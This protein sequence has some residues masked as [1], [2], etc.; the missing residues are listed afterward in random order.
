MKYKWKNLTEKRNEKQRLKKPILRLLQYQKSNGIQRIIVKT[1]DRETLYTCT[2]MKNVF[3]FSFLHSRN[4]KCSSLPNLLWRVRAI[5]CETRRERCA[6]DPS[7][8]ASVD[9]SASRLIQVNRLTWWFHRFQHLRRRAQD[10]D[11]VETSTLKL[12]VQNKCVRSLTN[13]CI[14][15]CFQLTK[16][17]HFENHLWQRQKQIVRNVEP[18]Q[19]C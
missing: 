9:F 5:R 2:R 19:L 7:T 17:L 12:C 8:V 3:S 11:W 18:E 10:L 1:R 6:G 4:S 14:V 15:A 16:F 13:D